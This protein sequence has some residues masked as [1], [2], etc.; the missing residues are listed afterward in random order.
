MQYPV[1]SKE[2]PDGRLVD[3]DNLQSYLS[4]GWVDAPDK[5]IPK[6]ETDDIA[7]EPEKVYNK[8]VTPPVDKR[9]GGRG[10]N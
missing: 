3:A 4:S 5:L 7:K 10:K 6:K 9:K 1:Y 8:P 2:Y